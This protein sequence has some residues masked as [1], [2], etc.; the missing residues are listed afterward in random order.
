[1]DK[2]SAN[3]LPCVLFYQ[4]LLRE[5]R[6]DEKAFSSNFYLT[7]IFIVL[8]LIAAIVIDSETDEVVREF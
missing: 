4:F 7:F 3:I 5:T 1:M 6:V 2:F 8:L